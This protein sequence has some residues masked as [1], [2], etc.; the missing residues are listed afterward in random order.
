MVK[1]SAVFLALRPRRRTVEQL[2]EQ[3]GKIHWLALPTEPKSP[4]TAPGWKVRSARKLSSA[5][6]RPS[7][8]SPSSSPTILTCSS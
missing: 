4:D 6:C 5:L 7:S 2:F 8:R 1:S 3:L